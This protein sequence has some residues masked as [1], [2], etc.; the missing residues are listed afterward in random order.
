MKH[1]IESFSDESD[2]QESLQKEFSIETAFDLGHRKPTYDSLEVIR[3]E[4]KIIVGL[5]QHDQDAQDFFENDDGAGEFIKFRNMEQREEQISKMS[6]TKKLIYMVDKYE[7]GTVHYSISGSTTPDRWDTSQGCAMF[8]PCDYIQSEFRKMKRKEGESVAFNHFIKDSN[9]V[10]SSYSDWCNG[11]VYGYSVITFDKKGKELNCDECWGFIGHKDANEEK[12]SVMENIAQNEV[13]NKLK[14]NVII[15]TVSPKD[16][17][18]PFRIAKKDL[19]EL[20]VAHVYDTY[21]V[22]AKYAGEDNVAVY[23]WKESDDKPTKAVFEE[24][25]KNYGVSASQFMEGRMNSDIKEA[26]STALTKEEEKQNKPK[27]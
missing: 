13:L 23:N 22:G 4:D 20:K 1:Q 3:T 18:L 10:L 26:I 25:Q 12:K 21:V 11:E 27:I 5:L 17:K 9:N 7:H 24:W 19:E 16:A 6:K 15:D 2:L 8:I 14:E